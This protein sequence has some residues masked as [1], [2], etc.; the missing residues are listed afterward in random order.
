MKKAVTS[1]ALVAMVA[2]YQ[3][4]A[5]AQETSQAVLV[6]EVIPDHLAYLYAPSSD[7]SPKGVSHQIFAIKRRWEPGRTLR[8]CFYN[9]NAAVVSLIRNVASEWNAYSGVVF[10]FGAPDRWFNCLDPRV[11][12]PQIRVGFSDRGYWSYIGSD[13][14]RYGGER[15]PSMNFDSFHR[16]YSEARYTA[17]DVVKRADPYHKGTIRHEFGH[18]LG[19]LHEHQNPN[20]HCIEEIKW[21]GPNNVYDYFAAPPNNWSPSEVDR[22]LGFVG[23]TDPD[24]VAAKPDPKSNMKYALPPVIL[25]TGTASPCAG[26]DNIELSDK[27]KQIVAVLYPKDGTEAAPHKVNESLAAAYVKAPP[28]FAAQDE[29]TE[30]VSRV[31]VDLDSDDVATRRNARAR[32][33]KLLQQDIDLQAADRLVLSMSTASYRYKLGLAV[34][35]A[36]TDKKVEVSPISA[37][38]IE[39]QLAQEKDATLQEN[40]KAAQKNINTLRAPNP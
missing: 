19:L 13:S 10:D 39:Q 8:V 5:S 38:V 24:Y 20:L 32:L 1:S 33:T 21:S 28:K 7:A 11:G 40:L 31:L 26:E 37:T 6:Q 15:A 2:L 14:E 17:D 12:F 9:G 30:F 23:V 25:K 29:T 16:I 4:S 3:L 27:D 22:N 35:L 34:A 18:A 36:N